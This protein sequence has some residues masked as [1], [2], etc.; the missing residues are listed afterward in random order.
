[1]SEGNQ[2]LLAVAEKVDEKKLKSAQTA[3]RKEIRRIGKKKKQEYLK[4]VQSDIE[5]LLHRVAALRRRQSNELKAER[6][7]TLA[8]ISFEQKRELSEIDETIEAEFADKHI[9]LLRAGT[10]AEYISSSDRE[11]VRIPVRPTRI[12][13]T[14]GVYAVRPVSDILRGSEVEVQ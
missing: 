5:D 12:N 9:D 11:S 2:A 6:K 10:L 13:Q 4:S 1:M 3:A 14:A 8:R 7:A